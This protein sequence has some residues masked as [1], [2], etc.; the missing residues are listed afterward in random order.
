MTTALGGDGTISI[1]SQHKSAPVHH[2]LSKKIENIPPD[3]NAVRL[4]QENST[5]KNFAFENFPCS[6]FTPFVK[7]KDEGITCMFAKDSFPTY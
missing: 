2:W 4:A 7:R 1:A 6:Y 3:L 5:L